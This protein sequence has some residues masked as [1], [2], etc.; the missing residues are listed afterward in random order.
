M[1]VLEVVATRERVSETDDPDAI[2]LFD[3]ESIDDSGAFSL[4]EFL[5][6]LPPAR[7]GDEQ[8]VLID[9]E[10]TYLDPST[11]P[12]EMVEGVDVSRDGSMPALGA[13]ASGRVINIRLKKNYRGAT[14]GVR[15][16]GSLDG[17]AGRRSFTFSGGATHKKLRVTAS[18]KHDIIDRLAAT[19]RTF[20]REQDHTAWG[21]R[22]L[23]LA[24]GSP[25]TVRAV[26]G[27][28]AD[29][30][31]AA[32][33]PVNVALVPQ[34]QNGLDLAASDF[35][36]GDD[37]RRRFNTSEYLS[38]V[39][40]SSRTGANVSLSYRIGPQLD[41][42]LTGSFTERRSE[43]TD[44]PPATEPSE[45]TVV[46]AALN[47]FGQDVE[48]GLVHVDFGPTRETTRSTNEQLE[49]RLNGRVGETWKWNTSAGYRGSDSRQV[50][51]DLDR[52]AFSA[53][54][55]ASDPAR[56]F[57]PF[58]D[59]AV[60]PINAHLYPGM[61]LH[62]T[63]NDRAEALNLRFSTVGRLA[64][65]WAGP[66]MTTLR[67]DYG[68]RERV[69]DTIRSNDSVPD[70]IRQRRD[71]HQESVH[72]TIPLVAAD[73]TRMWLRRLE[74]Q[75]AFRNSGQ[76][77]GGGERNYNAG[78][79]W[80]LNRSILFRTRYSSERETPGR[81]T[82]VEEETLVTTTLLDPLRPSAPATGIRVRSRDDVQAEP[83]MSD[84]FLLGARFEPTLLRGFR[85]SVDY[86]ARRNRNL[87]QDDFDPQ[88][89]VNNELAF[90]GRV[91]RA[92]PSAEDAALGL[93]GPITEIDVTP[94]N[95]GE[96]ER[97]DLRF[98]LEYQ[99]RSKTWG[100]VRFATFADRSLLA[101]HEVRSGVAFV[102]EGDRR[103][104]PPPW[105]F[106]STLSWARAPWTASTN[107]RYTGEVAPTSPLDTGIDAAT[108]VDLNATYQIRGPVWGRFIRN[109]RVGLS[110]G[111]VFATPPSRA[112]TLLGYRGSPLGRTYSVMATLPL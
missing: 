103:R 85:L 70:T 86:T 51:T 49:L 67:A 111:N 24:W 75:L 101:R 108:L 55:A 77:D 68:S 35:I 95:A 21:G 38:I 79:V 98:S 19:E 27:P 110:I 23:R 62:R 83:E 82:A 109:V 104:N 105:S 2:E 43:K 52:D 12:L 59:P 97:R 60:E 39:A 22:D 61:T 92:E 54:L 65:G 32:G 48:I 11:I 90:P 106:R 73:D 40:P 66:I 26:A 14:F 25:A 72:A 3:R 112:D 102:P 81:T 53:A 17:G 63:R 20:S 57:N 76:S 41:L 84:R 46:P 29:L 107:I 5:E 47:P 34:G 31:N 69:R 13:Y 94:G 78:V 58:G 30:T 9:G 15:F 28:L 87:V 56:R 7:D 96:T 4:D 1:Q 36:A 71:S 64:R 99:I 16:G 91:I 33:D 8:L 6:T 80:S 74:T 37:G 89:I 42:S 18:L 44:A 93:P 88:E 50:A 10:P 100:R 45:E